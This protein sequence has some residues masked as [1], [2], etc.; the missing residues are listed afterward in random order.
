MYK[1]PRIIPC[2]TMQHLDLVKTINFKEPRYIG[3][4]VNSVKIFNNK[5]VDR[6]SV[7]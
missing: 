4:P 5:N 2:L 1:R 6:K 3:D 7:V